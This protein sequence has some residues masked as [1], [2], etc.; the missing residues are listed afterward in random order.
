MAKAAAGALALAISGA[1]LNVVLAGAYRCIDSP[2]FYYPPALAFA[3]G[4]AGL[5]FFGA[6]TLA[7]GR[8]RLWLPIVLLG[9]LSLALALAGPRFKECGPF[10]G[11]RVSLVSDPSHAVEGIVAYV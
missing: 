10:Q 9:T 11:I 3:W 7:R 4:G 8:R 6:T 2:E 1:A 5:M